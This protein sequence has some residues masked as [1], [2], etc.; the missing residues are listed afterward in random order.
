MRP[1]CRL[2]QFGTFSSPPTR[3][4]LP[5]TPPKYPLPQRDVFLVRLRLSSSKASILAVM[6]RTL[7]PFPGRFCTR[8]SGQALKRSLKVRINHRIR[9]VSLIGPWRVVLGRSHVRTNCWAHM[10]TNSAELRGPTIALSGIL[11]RIKSSAL[12]VTPPVPSS[13]RGTQTQP[14]AINMHV[15]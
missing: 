4:I 5:S 11:S 14:R 12:C 7:Q 8:S 1:L 9:T 10:R 15:A 13:H 3:T 2:A 6:A